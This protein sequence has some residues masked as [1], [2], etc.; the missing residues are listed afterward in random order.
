ML[1]EFEEG[2]RVF[3]V[4]AHAPGAAALDLAELVEALWEL[5][6][7]VDDVEGDFLIERNGLPRRARGLPPPA[8]GCG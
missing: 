1:V 3:E 2:G 7:G 8:A 5:A 6:I 4:A